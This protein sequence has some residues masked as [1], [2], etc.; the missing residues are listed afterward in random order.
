M[1]VRRTSYRLLLPLPPPPP[2]PPHCT[3]VPSRRAAPPAARRVIDLDHFRVWR[4]DG[5]PR[6]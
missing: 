2:P 5:A 3:P 6:A 4:C 1:R